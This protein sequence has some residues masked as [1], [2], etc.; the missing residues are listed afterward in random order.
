MNTNSSL[1]KTNPKGVEEV[2]AALIGNVVSPRQPLAPVLESILSLKQKDRRFALH[3]LEVISVSNTELAYYYG[4]YAAQA[5]GLLT[6]K[7]LRLWI[8]QTLQLYDIEGLYPA[9]R[10]LKDVNAFQKRF[11]ALDQQVTFEEMRSILTP[12]L[13]GLAGR[14]LKLKVG[15]SQF[16]DTEVLYLPAGL[17]V[18]KDKQKNRS[19]YKAMA[20]FMWAQTWF[21][22]FKKSRLSSLSLQQRLSA[23]YAQ[24][25]EATVLNGFL[26]LE[27]VRLMAYIERELP[28]L[29]REMSLLHS[30]ATVDKTWQVL[31]QPLLEAEASVEDTLA[32]LK[33]LLSLRIPL[34]MVPYVGDLDLN[35]VELQFQ[36]R[37]EAL[38][39]SLQDKLNQGFSKDEIEDELRNRQ[40][41]NDEKGQQESSDFKPNQELDDLMNQL[42]AALNQD[43]NDLDDDWLAP[44]EEGGQQSSSSQ[45]AQLPKQVTNEG[46]VFFYDEWDHERQQYREAWCRLVEKEVYPT[47][48][49]FAM[50]TKQKYH[51]LI[52]QIRKVFEMVKDQPQLQRNQADGE[53]VDI[54]AVIQMK[55]NL[56]AGEEISDRFYMR[57]NRNERSFAV[58]LLIDLSGSTK[59]WI[60]DAERESLLL[61]VEALEIL[62]DQ[63][64]IYG[65]SGLTRQRCEMYPVKTFAQTNRELTTNKICALS[66]KDYTR[67]G[68]AIRHATVQ[69]RAVEAKHKLLIVLSDGKPDDYDGYKG[70]YGIQDTRRSIDEAHNSGVRS[71][72]ITIDQQ[73][74][75]YLP[76]LFGP[77]RYTILNDVKKLPQ[78]LAQIYQRITG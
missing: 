39:Q 16:T 62:G 13:C 38:M 66:A 75:D 35:G 67:M 24:A 74:Q 46:E 29:Y 68:V 1:S 58:L 32:A 53:E 27:N 77:H 4:L 31:V 59:G 43:V 78:K 3:W 49:E 7:A 11:V 45:G 26:A 20:C 23:F 76:T 72:G 56:H 17:A 9:V 25:D 40:Q 6:D 5:R 21:G 42:E 71:F 57:K 63:Y 64:A 33:K 14:E 61:M 41:N 12:Y 2:I 22:T 51:H 28:G 65:F 10:F 15:S 8:G 36:N 30:K 69:L 54:D 55:A 37:Q 70:E 52:G 18:Y 60:N 47:H 73:A 50:Q 48:G 19:L 44:L 34:P